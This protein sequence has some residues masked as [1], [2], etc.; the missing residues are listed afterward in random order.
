MPNPV[1]SNLVSAKEIVRTSCNT[2]HNQDTSG[3]TAMET[4]HGKKPDPSSVT[5]LGSD[6][7]KE[8]AQ[9]HCNLQ[10]GLPLKQWQAFPHHI[11]G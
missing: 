1:A 5:P 6:L 8:R 10:N 3:F 2:Q 7:S 9:Q 4:S 11:K